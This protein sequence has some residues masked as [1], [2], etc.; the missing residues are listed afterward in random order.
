[1]SKKADTDDRRRRALERAEVATHERLLSIRAEL[2]TLVDTLDSI[3][4]ARRP[5]L[6]AGIVPNLSGV[7]ALSRFRKR[8][9]A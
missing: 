7:I 8:G 4:I 5:R 1:M 6:H 9:G 2:S 3:V